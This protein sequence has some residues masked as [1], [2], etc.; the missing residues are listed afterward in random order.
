LAAEGPASVAFNHALAVLIDGDRFEQAASPLEAGLAAAREQGSLL[1]LASLTGLKAIIVWRRGSLFDVE[2]LSRVVLELLADSGTS[3]YDPTYWAYLA[4][5]LVERAEL[6]QAEEALARTG[7]GPDMPI[8]TSRGMPL[9]AR[10]R[11]RLAQGRGQEALADLLELRTRERA[12]GVRHM[13]FPWRRDAVQAALALDDRALA[14]ELATEQL[15]LTRRWDIP[16][17]RG[18]ALSSAGL[19]TGGAEG[20]ELLAQGVDVLACSPARLDYARALADLGAALRR[21]G[22]RAQARE[23]LTEAI[24][25]AQ[26]CGASA[27]AARAHQELMTAGARPRRLQFTGAAALTAGER[28]IAALAA[29]GNSNRQIAAELFITTRTVENHL[30]SCYRKLGISSRSQLPAALGQA[31]R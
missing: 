3:L 20:L 13:R 26:A 21:A 28:R 23:P 30:A 12:L 19:A 7:I 6:R 16:S 27:L 10:A 5:A 17:A 24:Q 4:A 11:L 15:K 2:A 1:G 25:V 29:Q 9:F 14:E 31:A 18:I 8:L 22:R